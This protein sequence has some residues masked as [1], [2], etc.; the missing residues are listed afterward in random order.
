MSQKT[1][2]NKFAFGQMFLNKV[3]KQNQDESEDEEEEDA[4]LKIE[5]DKEFILNAQYYKLMA[6]AHMMELAAK[7]QVHLNS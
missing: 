3:L 7:N 2:K 4:E 5:K 6:M 1:V